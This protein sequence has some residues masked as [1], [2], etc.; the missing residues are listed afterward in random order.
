MEVEE[1]YNRG[2]SN[3]SQFSN[4]KYTIRKQESDKFSNVIPKIYKGRA[5]I[6]TAKNFQLSEP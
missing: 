3:L 5:M 1:E 6:T 2:E 4:F